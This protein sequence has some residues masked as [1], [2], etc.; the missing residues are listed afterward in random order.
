MTTPKTVVQVYNGKAKLGLDLT[1][2][3]DIKKLNNGNDGSI[4]SSSDVCGFTKMKKKRKRD[5][6]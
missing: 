5:M 2:G 6:R 1:G 4:T 3:L